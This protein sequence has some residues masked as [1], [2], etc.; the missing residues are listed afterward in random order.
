[1]HP[2]HDLTDVS[3]HLPSIAG[4]TSWIW[5]IPS[6]PGLCLENRS[7][8]RNTLRR[9]SARY[10]RNGSPAHTTCGLIFGLTPTNVRSSVQCVAKRL[11]DNTTENGTRGFTRAK[12][13][14][15]VEVSCQE[16]V[17]GAVGVGL[18]VQ[19][20]SAAT[21]GQK[22]AESVSSRYWTKSPK[23][24][25]VSRRNSNSSSSSRQ[26]I[27]NLSHNHSLCPAFL[28]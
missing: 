7:V 1:M 28:V 9:S 11:P 10:V 19:M 25:S 8:F 20:L 12:R 21:S 4:T 23:N 5:L 26:D 16:V 3:Q 2:R 6:D 24:E 14:L 27:C 17:I 18:L 15:F 22:R 13:S